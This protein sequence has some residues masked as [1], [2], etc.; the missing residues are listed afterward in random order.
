MTTVDD[1]W[2][3]AARRIGVF[4]SPL[5]AIGLGVGVLAVY[6][7]V[8]GLGGTICCRLSVCLRRRTVS[9]VLGELPVAFG[10]VAAALLFIRLFLGVALLHPRSECVYHVGYANRFLLRPVG[11]RSEF[12]SELRRATL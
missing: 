12:R 10:F 8:A 11:L 2:A 7:G 3:I 4:G 5:G 9:F 6:E 1:V